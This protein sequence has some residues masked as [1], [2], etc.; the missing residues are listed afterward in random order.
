MSLTSAAP[1]I[2]PVD[3]S[4]IEALA[5]PQSTLYGASSQ[6]GAIR[7]I[8]NKPDP[9][10]FTANIGGGVSS[11][12]GGGTGYQGWEARSREGHAQDGRKHPDEALPH[13]LQTN[14]IFHI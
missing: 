5:G 6:S 1:D 9:S 14:R 7:V 3:L 8:T 4:R 13:D 12:S 10:E 2:Y 11:T